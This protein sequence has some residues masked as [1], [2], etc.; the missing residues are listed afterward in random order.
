M[1][2]YYNVETMTYMVY[3]SIIIVVY[4]SIIIYIRYTL[5]VENR[6]YIVLEV[7][8]T[9]RP[10]QNITCLEQEVVQILYSFQFQFLCG[11]WCIKET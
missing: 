5:V 1:N 9:H 11:L 6:R 10:T 4:F 3:F 2:Y 7:I 8:L